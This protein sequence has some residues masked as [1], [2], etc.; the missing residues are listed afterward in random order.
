LVKNVIKL[1]VPTKV[2]SLYFY[3]RFNCKLALLFQV[4]S[5]IIIKVKQ[6]SAA[7]DFKRN[8]QQGPQ[9][10]QKCFWAARE[11]VREGESTGLQSLMTREGGI[12]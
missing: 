5:G 12:A 6:I 11:R 9:T 2:V 1:K 8:P 10:W 4:P 3:L 7:Y